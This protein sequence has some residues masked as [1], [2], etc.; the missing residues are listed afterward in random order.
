MIKLDRTFLAVPRLEV[1][2]VFLGGAGFLPAKTFLAGAA[3]AFE[4]AVLLA[5]ALEVVVLLVGAL[6]GLDFFAAGL[7]DLLPDLGAAFFAG[8]ALAAAV[9]TVLGFAAA[10]GLAAA[11]LF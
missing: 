9:L 2:V 7:A 6:A 1:V 8:V 3:L 11:G 5:G 4:A 10:L